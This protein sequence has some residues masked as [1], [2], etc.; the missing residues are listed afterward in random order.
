MCLYRE[1]ERLYVEIGDRAIH[2]FALAGQ[3]SLF[4]QLGD[5]EEEKAHF[6]EQ[7]ALDLLVQQ[8][9]ITRDLGDLGNTAASLSNQGRIFA[10][11]GKRERALELH[12]KAADLFRSLGDMPGPGSLDDQAGLLDDRERRSVFIESRED[13]QRAPAR[14]PRTRC[15]PLWAI[16][17]SSTGTGATCIA[18]WSCSSRRRGSAVTRTF[19]WA[20]SSRSPSRP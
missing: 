20:C 1:V 8:E 13:L 19:R 12:G 16:R 5:D 17:R 4:M 15:R 14:R 2:A 18:R 7:R 3:A 10:N 6:E 9:L 11:W